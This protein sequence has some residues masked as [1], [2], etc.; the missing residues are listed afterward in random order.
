MV[1]GG[2]FFVASCLEIFIASAEHFF[3]G[4]FCTYYRLSP[5]FWWQLDAGFTV[6]HFPFSTVSSWQLKQQNN[7]LPLCLSVSV[8]HFSSGFYTRCRGH[9]SHFVGYL[10]PKRLIRNLNLK[11]KCLFETFNSHNSTNIKEKSPYFYSWFN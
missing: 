3:Y 8:C 11:M 4:R 10:E 1:V 9:I 2:H 7:C 5:F 6:E